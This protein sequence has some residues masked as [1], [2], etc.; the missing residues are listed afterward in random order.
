MRRNAHT[1]VVQLP[2]YACAA[3]S[4]LCTQTETSG[5]ARRYIIGK[6]IG[7]G[8]FGVVREAIQKGSGIPFA[9]KSVPKVPKRGVPTPRYL[10]KLRQ[11]VD[12]MQQLGASLD[13]VYLA[14]RRSCRMSMFE[15]KLLSCHSCH[16]GSFRKLCAQMTQVSSTLAQH[17]LE[18]DVMLHKVS[19]CVTHGAHAHQLS[20]ICM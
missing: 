8:S 18:C 9:V 17:W 13:A 2:R 14:V 16:P 3:A 20:C 15:V 12:A 1:S 7:A 5:G 4:L 10:L 11:E 19:C 6:V